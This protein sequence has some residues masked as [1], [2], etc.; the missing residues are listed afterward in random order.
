[1]KK[2]ITLISKMLRQFLT[3]LMFL[4]FTAPTLGV[5]AADEAGCGLKAEL[6]TPDEL[7]SAVDECL[8]AR[9]KW[10]PNSITDFVC[11]QWDFSMSNNQAY[12]N[13]VVAYLVAANIALNTAD[14]DI[15][16]YM[17]RLQDMRERDP[18]KWMENIYACIGDPVSSKSVQGIYRNICAFGTLEN[19]L[20]EWS[21]K[22]YIYDISVYPQY[23]CNEKVKV[24]IEGWD[25]LAKIFMSDGIYKNQKNDTDKWITQVKWS[26]GRVL[27]LWHDYQKILGRAVSKMTGYNRQVVWQ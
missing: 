21:E 11:P 3:I 16:E 19:R 15:K 1:M 8:E 26:Y 25:K 20:N 17:K 24:K 14:K 18:T 2:K 4:I 12:N 5:F 23:L 10:N 9:T 7:R 27:G 13:Q 6:P 22:Q